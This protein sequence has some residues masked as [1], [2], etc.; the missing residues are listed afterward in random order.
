MWHYI[1][2]GQ[3][4]HL[5][6]AY[7]WLVLPGVENNRRLYTHRQSFASSCT[8]K[9]QRVRVS[10]PLF[11]PT[12]KQENSRRSHAKEEKQLNASPDSDVTMQRC[13]PRTGQG[14]CFL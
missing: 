9:L 7:F 2:V 6:S 4:F 3:L 1:F 10:L 13:T 12:K 8:V 14:I 5:Q 11:I